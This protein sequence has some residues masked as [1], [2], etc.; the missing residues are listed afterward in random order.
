M[1]V[2]RSGMDVFTHLISNVTFDH[3]LKIFSPFRKNSI[4]LFTVSPSINALE[5][6][7]VN[8]ELQSRQYYVSPTSRNKNRNILTQSFIDWY[9]VVKALPSIEHDSIGK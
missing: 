6:I 7:N 8:D 9:K 5:M 1:L 3:Q 4:H 2:V